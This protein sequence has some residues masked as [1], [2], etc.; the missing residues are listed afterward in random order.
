MIIIMAVEKSIIYITN[1][2]L[3][4][5]S[6]ISYST[7]DVNDDGVNY[8][9]F[10]HRLSPLLVLP[11]LLFMCSF[12]IYWNQGHSPALNCKTRSQTNCTP[13]RAGYLLLINI[14]SYLKRVWACWE[15]DR[16][17]VKIRTNVVCGFLL[18][19]VFWS[20]A[21]GKGKI[22]NLESTMLMSRTQLEWA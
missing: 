16:P 3:K 17:K 9:E 10:G 18:K 6:E 22:Q 19:S 7:T 15:K 4:L 20:G 2:H 1:Y 12:N 8:C 21:C 14:I 13:M 11:W 5:V